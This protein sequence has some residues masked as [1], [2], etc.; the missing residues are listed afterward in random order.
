MEDQPFETYPPAAQAVAVRN[1][2]VAKIDADL[3]KLKEIVATDIPAFHGAVARL[4][5]P[6]V[7]VE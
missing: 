2:L 5:A 4:D 7:V 3:A 1:E 6:D